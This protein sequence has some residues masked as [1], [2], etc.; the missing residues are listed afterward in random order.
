ME[1]NNPESHLNNR[2]APW[3]N[4]GTTIIE[5]SIRDHDIQDEGSRREGSNLSAYI[6]VM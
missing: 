1:H 6:N 5:E 2:Q 4:Y 3:R